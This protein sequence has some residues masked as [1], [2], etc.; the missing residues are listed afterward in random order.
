M[1]DVI[2]IRRLLSL[3][4][5]LIHRRLNSPSVR[6]EI[7]VLFVCGLLGSAGLLYFMYDVMNT[8]PA[9]QGFTYLPYSLIGIA[10]SPLMLL[11]LAW[12]WY[13]LSSH[14]LANM[15]NGRGP[16]IR[17]LRT[18]AW[19]LIPVA[20]WLL[21]RSIVITALFYFEDLPEQPDEALVTPDALANYYLELGLEDPVYVAIM[22]SS[23]LF[24]AWSWH[25]LSISIA[26]A[27]YVSLD[28]AKR[29]AAVPAGTLA[30]YLLNLTWQ[31][32]GFF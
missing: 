18:S 14:F 28:T 12:V 7:V 6:L 3:P 23:V 24:V 26:E 13:S 9:D 1:T 25:L 29:I 19:S 32:Q 30:L 20:I 27:K 11:L 15:A 21:I 8:V 4:K 31:W 10:A 16:M 22:A 17:L 5:P 2:M